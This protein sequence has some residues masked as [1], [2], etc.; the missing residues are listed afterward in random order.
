DPQQAEGIVFQLVLVPLPSHARFRTLQLFFCPAF[1]LS[2]GV[3]SLTISSSIGAG[4]GAPAAR[5]RRRSAS[6]F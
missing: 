2:L 3:Y 1:Y 4:H 6:L 5:P